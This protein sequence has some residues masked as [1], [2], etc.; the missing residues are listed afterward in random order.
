MNSL[1][2]RRME[3]RRRERA[4]ETE[5]SKFIFKLFSNKAYKTYLWSHKQT[6]LCGSAVLLS[7]ATLKN[8]TLLGQCRP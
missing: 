2:N 5:T 4:I 8:L 3:E 7:K 6:T 1:Y